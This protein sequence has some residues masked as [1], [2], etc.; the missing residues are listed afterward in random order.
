M[1]NTDFFYRAK[2][3]IEILVNREQEYIRRSNK[4][5]YESEFD[6][7]DFQD[8]K[9]WIKDVTISFSDKTIEKV[10]E[11]IRFEFHNCNI[12]VQ[13][14][15]EDGYFYYFKNNCLVNNERLLHRTSVHVEYSCDVKLED[16][17]FIKI[18]SKEE[19][20]EIYKNPKENNDKSDDWD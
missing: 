10:I 2:I 19:T 7:T 3:E 8:A 6:E 15:I 12:D 5:E 14:L 13:P 17:D 18:A 11:R 9:R 16:D 1:K 20:K 4:V